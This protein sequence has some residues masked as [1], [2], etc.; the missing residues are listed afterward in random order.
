[1]RT[2]P[3]TQLTILSIDDH[4]PDEYRPMLGLLHH[5]FDVMEWL[6]GGGDLHDGGAQQPER[7]KDDSYVYLESIIPGMSD[8]DV[9][10]S[11]H[12]GKILIRVGR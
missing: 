1:M 3:F 7:W 8:R 9:D 6:G 10:I 2:L 12:D 5:L 11:V 4:P